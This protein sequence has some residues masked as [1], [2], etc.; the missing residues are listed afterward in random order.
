MAIDIGDIELC[1]RLVESG[2]DLG[3]DIEGC[4]GCTPLLYSLHKDQYVI[5]EY[6]VSQ[7]ATTAGSTCDL[8]GTRGF[9]ALHYAAASGNVELLRLLLEKSP[10][11]VFLNHNPIHPIHL[12]IWHS[13][14]DCVKFILDH[15]SQGTNSHMVVILH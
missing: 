7:G 5:A 15:V 10:N 4:S 11:E 12:A 8:W 1:T 13:N 6:L 9:T 2:T 3:A 14:A